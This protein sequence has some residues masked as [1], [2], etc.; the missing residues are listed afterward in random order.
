M[1]DLIGV[2]DILSFLI[3]ALEL[4]GDFPVDGALVRKAHELLDRPEPALDEA[5][6]IMLNEPTLAA[7]IL[8]AA[9]SAKHNRDCPVL[10]LTQAAT[11]L[12]A[13]SLADI[14]AH[15]PQREGFRQAAEGNEVFRVRLQ[16]S[17][18]MRLITSSLM[19]KWGFENEER[20]HLGSIL[21]SVGPILMSYYFPQVFESGIERAATRNQSVTKSIQETLG[22]AP[23]G[24]SIGMVHTLN[25]PDF[26]REA[27]SG[28]YQ[29]YPGQANLTVDTHLH[30]LTR[31]IACGA[32]CADVL[33]SEIQAGS[34]DQVLHDI[35]RKLDIERAELKEI[36]QAL[37]ERYSAFCHAAGISLGSLTLDAEAEFPSLG[38]VAS[39]AEL[40]EEAPHNS[41]LAYFLREI[42]VAAQNARS[43][44]NAATAAMEAL[45][46]ALSFDRVALFV[47]EEGEHGLKRVLSLGKAFP[48]DFEL[49]ADCEQGAQNPAQMALESGVI[50]NHGQA[51]VADGVVFAALPIGGKGRTMGVIYADRLQLPERIDP[52]SIEKALA[53]LAKALDRA[54]V[55]LGI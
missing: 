43:I 3:Q 34:P 39:V 55:N 2:Q 31:A 42:E 54:V 36:L 27:L 30:P 25:V 53:V 37:P 44:T 41:Q 21:L 5:V 16:Q 10:T 35:E 18:V 15:C 1:K 29:I 19:K 17:V 46:F 7:R 28:A 32:W 52:E 22:M 20:S 40:F 49:L 45:A 24:I 11:E 14:L 38:K 50:Q 13:D 48:E 8:H 4:P 9:N 51:L 33:F 47:P 6:A 23:Y 26:Y 12:G